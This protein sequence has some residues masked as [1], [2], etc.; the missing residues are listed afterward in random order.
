M[1][2]K[3]TESQCRFAMA[4]GDFD[5]ALVA[6]KPF[7]ALVLTQSWCPQWA[8]MRSYCDSIEADGRAS[9]YYIE[10][11]LEPFFEDFFEL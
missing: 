4:H 1:P 9:I 5:P 3:L 11:D 6:A 7:V 8:A 10:Y 2:Q